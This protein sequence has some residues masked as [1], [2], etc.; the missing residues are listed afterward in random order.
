MS[1]TTMCIKESLRL[2]PTVIG[3]SRELSKPITF[4]D[5]RSL[6]A[7]LAF[8]PEAVPRGGGTLGTT[9]KDQWFHN[10]WRSQKTILKTLVKVGHLFSKSSVGIALIT[11]WL[12]RLSQR[13]ITICSKLYPAPVFPESEPRVSFL[14]GHCF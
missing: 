8:F 6:P 13:H 9:V 10:S 2:T 11:W 5:G 1:Y 14:L 4:S 3:F 12:Q 7:G